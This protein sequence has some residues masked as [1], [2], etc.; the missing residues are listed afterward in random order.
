MPHKINR[1]TKKYISCCRHKKSN[2]K[3]QRKDGKI[4]CLP[5]KFSRKRCISSKI[6][7]FSMRSSCS[8]YIDCR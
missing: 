2:K 7:G 5:R 8:P 6:K 1:K 3:C 4:F